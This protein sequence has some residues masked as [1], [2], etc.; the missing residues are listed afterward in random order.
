[1]RRRGGGSRGR[2]DGKFLRASFFFF[3]CLRVEGILAEQ[4]RFFLLGEKD[5]ILWCGCL[6]VPTLL[7]KH[8][9]VPP[10][11]YLLPQGFDASVHELGEGEGVPNPP[12]PR[13]A[14]ALPPPRGSH[15]VEKKKKKK[16]TPPFPPSALRSD[17]KMHSRGGVLH[18][19]F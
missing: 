13:P 19:G 6:S 10:T 18:Y 5:R 8:E 1:M 4:C 14:G 12:P 7:W 3:F 2:R 9:L 17:H 15:L 16:E 11:A